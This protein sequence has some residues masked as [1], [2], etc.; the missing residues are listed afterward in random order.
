MFQ[1][2]IPVIER[3]TGGRRHAGLSADSTDHHPAFIIRYPRSVAEPM[4]IP[5][6]QDLISK[7]TAIE[8]S[9]VESK[10]RGRKSEW[11]LATVAFANSTPIGYPAVLFI[12]VDDSGKIQDGGNPESDM[13]SYSDYISAHSYPPIYTYPHALLKEGRECVAVIIPGS[14]LRPHFAGK[15]YVREGTETK[16]AQPEQVAAL[17]AQTNSKT[18]ELLAWAGKEITFATLNPAPHG[19]QD[20]YA[21]SPIR[22]LTANSPYATFQTLNS[23]PDNMISYSLHRLELG[24]DH[25]RNRLAVFFYADR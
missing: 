19:Y 25:R 3:R 5:S 13:K 23:G 8:D 24:F 17:V 11:L 10:P 18:R 7:L 22:V 9:F 16:E 4:L 20:S 15:A 12:G 1:L 21:S 2:R 14:E 6:N